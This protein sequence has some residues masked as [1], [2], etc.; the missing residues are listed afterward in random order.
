M[1]DIT[2]FF[3]P[4]S[5][6]FDQT[7]ITNSEETI[8][9]NSRIFEKQELWQSKDILDNSNVVLFAFPDFYKNSKSFLIG[10]KAIREKLY[11]M[12]KLNDSFIFYDLGNFKH[13][14]KNSDYESGLNMVLETLFEANV[15]V[16]ILSETT[17]P[18]AVAKTLAKFSPESNV[19]MVN[20]HFEDFEKV[21]MITEDTTLD[22]NFGLLGYQNYLTQDSHIEY[23]KNC[24]MEFVRISEIK[25]KI[26]DAEPYLR[27]AEWTAL[28]LNTINSGE[29]PAATKPSPN[30]MNAEEFCALPYY[31]GLGYRNKIISFSGY[32]S[33]KDQNKQSAFLIAQSIWLYLKGFIGHFPEHPLTNKQ[34]IQRYIVINEEFNKHFIFYKSS[35]SGRWWM[36][37]PTKK[38]K[39][40]IVA[41]SYKDYKM[42]SRQEIPERWWNLFKRYF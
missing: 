2:S 19:L 14:E 41:A 3:D 38:K 11:G 15:R 28:S 39:P 8:L 6:E 1:I 17:L 21:K 40:V 35:L 5:I 42:T 34:N 16:I 32:E 27:D 12:A 13:V 7:F 20:N 25:F 37:I 29:A 22:L 24:F 10:A 30:G 4:V 31:A 26:Q 18:Y 36:E 23:G 33:S 9:T